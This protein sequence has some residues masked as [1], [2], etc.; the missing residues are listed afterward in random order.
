MQRILPVLLLLTSA[1]AQQATPPVGPVPTI[2]GKT[3]S[4]Q[5]MP[6]YFPLYWEEKTGKLWLE[7]DK[8]DVEF[9]YV[10]SMPAGMGSNDLGLDRGQIGGSR[11]VRFER[12]GPKVLLIQPNYRYRSITDDAAERRAADQSFAQSVLWGFDVQAEEGGRVLV[13]ATQFYLRDAHHIPSTL[14]RA[15]Q[16]TFRADLT[17][18]AFYLPRTKNFPKNTEVEATLT[19][20]G[21]NPGGFVRDV[22]PNPEAITVREHHSFVELPGPGF[23]SRVFDPRSGYIVSS[24]TDYAAPLDGRMPQRFILRHRLQKKNPAAPVSEPVQPIVYYLDPGAPEPVRS[25]LLEGAR[26]WNQAFEAAGYKDAFHV[27]LLPDGA[28]PMDIRY[29]MI[30]WVHRSTRGWSTGGSISDPRTGEIIKGQVTLGSLRARQDYMIFEG[31]LAPYLDGKTIPA[32]LSRTVLAR[33]R[34]LAA[35]EVGHTLGLAHNFAASVKDRAS[36]MDYPPPFV[37]LNASGVPDLSDA[38]ATGIG[39]WDKIAINFGYRDF[40]AG[41]DE[42]KQLDAILRDATARGFIFISDADAR[43]E[44]GA[45]PLAHLWDS[46]TNAVDELN[47][48]LDV[49]AK[50][51]SRYSANVIRDGE[52]LS[53]LEDVLV[54]IYLLHRYQTEAASKVLGGLYYSYAFRGDGQ[55]ITERIPGVEQRRAL[56]ALLHTIESG[57]LTLGPNILALI[58][59]RAEGYNRTREDFHNRTGLTFDPIGAAES[60]ASLTVGLILNPQRAARLVEYHAEDPSS[61]GLAEVIDRLMAVTLRARP[62]LGLAAEVQRAVGAVVLYNLMVLAANESAPAEVRAIA[63]FKLTALSEWSMVEAGADENT[64]AFYT[65]AVEQVKRFEVNPKDI[66][67]PKPADP[68]PGQ[69]IG[70]ESN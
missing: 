70:C 35:H 52:P 5:K 17:R 40:P 48:I 16:G 57:A 56:E 69:P 60:A 26:W 24:F 39:T 65:W 12:S 6:G 30:N 20:T 41:T 38:Y 18:S 58:P 53:N 59:P 10:D 49:R 11:I 47:R 4:M 2:S 9:L 67:I 36:V 63:M 51:L 28:D 62:G 13:D 15:N 50:A 19:F 23:R 46:G 7:I 31:L 27:E 43:P 29:N 14:Q 37:K 21:E 68:P 66:G 22:T 54:P 32:E 33:M 34:Q 42:K 3:G 55:K 45:H 25:A 8:F 64:R 61:P 44:G 1:F